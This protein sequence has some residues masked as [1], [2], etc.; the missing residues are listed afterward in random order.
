[1]SV[2]CVGGIEAVE[3][4]E[5]LPIPQGKEELREHALNRI[6]YEAAK[7]IG[8]KKRIVKAVKSWHRDTYVCGRCGS[9]IGDAWFNYCPN[10][11]TAILKNEYTEKKIK[12]KQEE[13]HQMN[14]MEWLEIGE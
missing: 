14:I 10:C 2:Q 6:K 13:N 7:G 1:M 4:F 11:G 12:E 5:S 9:G 8:V 3:Y